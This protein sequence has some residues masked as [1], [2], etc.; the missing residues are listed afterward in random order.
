MLILQSWNRLVLPLAMRLVLASQVQ[1]PARARD[2]VE[3]RVLATTNQA[4]DLDLLALDL[5]L[6]SLTRS[7]RLPVQDNGVAAALP[8][9]VLALLA[10]TECHILLIPTGFLPA[11]AF[12]P[13]RRARGTA[14]DI[15]L[16]DPQA[17]PALQVLMDLPVCLARA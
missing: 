15:R 13:V 9:L 11:K 3:V 17:P 10:S 6:T 8:C 14:L 5:V 1:V 12:L 7:T 4:L 2:R 16:R